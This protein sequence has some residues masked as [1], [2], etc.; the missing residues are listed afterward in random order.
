MMYSGIE[1]FGGVGSFGV[2]VCMYY[3][4][5]FICGNYILLNVFLAIAVDNLGDAESLT[6]ADKEK[7][8]EEEKAKELRAASKSPAVI[9]NSSVNKKVRMF[10]LLVDLL[11]YCLPSII[12]IYSRVS[13]SK[14]CKCLVW[15]DFYQ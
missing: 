5:L 3:V 2:I 14:K 7:E 9:D 10:S 8:E 4:V 1:S 12:Y 6:E 11:N 15:V 13:N